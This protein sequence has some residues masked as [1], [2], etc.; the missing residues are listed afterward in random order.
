MLPLAVNA[1]GY[2]VTKKAHTERVALTKR[3]QNMINDKGF[4]E[5]FVDYSE[6]REGAPTLTVMVGISGSG[7]SVLAKRWVNADKRGNVV[8]FNRDN[9]RAMLYVDVPWSHHNEELTRQYEQDGVKLALR[10][11]KDAIVDDTNC[12]L[13]VRNA[14]EEVARN[15]RVKFRLVV[16][17]TTLEECILR[18][19][20]R[21]GKECVG[22]AIVR[23]QYKDLN[24]A[25]VIPVAYGLTATTRAELDREGFRSGEFTR[26]LPAAPFLLVDIDGTVANHIGVRGPF[27]EHKVLND[28]VWEKVA[29]MVRAAY[30]THNIVFLSGRHLTCSDD[31]EAWLKLHN[32]PFDFLVMRS[33]GDNR[34]D[35]EIKPELLQEIL[36]TVRMDEIDYVIDDRPRVVRAWRRLGLKVVVVYAGEVVKDFTTVHRS[37]CPQEGKKGY[38]RCDKCGAL[39]DF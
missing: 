10:M 30:A 21:E 32:I 35:A 17:T 24:G 2:I 33:A 8:R 39:E 23:R 26:R 9:L 11:G 15:S 28:T 31:T 5:Q 36:T 25:N 34:S 20:K 7:K 4:T 3:D 29:D 16:M 6:N 37:G 22:E 14:W 1:E 13:R 19:S 12:N 27:E 18:D 38:R